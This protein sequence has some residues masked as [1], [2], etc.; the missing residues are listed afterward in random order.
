M[1]SERARIVVAFHLPF[2][3]PLWV[4]ERRG[5]FREEG[6]DVTIVTP[7]PG[8]TVD[9]IMSGEADL[10]LSGVMR[11]FILADRP[12]PRHLV[13]IAEVNSRDGF[14]I[15]SRERADGFR[16]SDL[17]GKRLALFGLAPTPWMCLQDVMRRNG[18]DPG[19]ITLLHG[20]G[21]AEGIAALRDGGA[22]YL[23]TGQPMA[24]ELLEDGVAH[25]AAAQ[26]PG[27]G[28]VPY[29]S[30]IVTPE[31]R[32]TRPDL[33]EKAVRALARALRWMAGQG[34]GAIADLIAPE[35]PDTRP[36][37]LHQVVGRYHAAGTWSDGP[38]QKREAFERLGAMLAAGGLIARAASYDALVDDTFAE[39]ATR[40][41]G[42]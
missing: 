26:A 34:G 18:V 6:L 7:P 16:W 11:S 35:F 41:V 21:V 25:L 3:T 9:M 31:V 30:F 10:A 29:S 38:R 24:E 37:I 22:D 8:K 33:C 20:L 13:A 28:H 15:L 36:A 19:T 14:F 2:Y 1:N 4:A 40:A 39:A 5:A 17:A 12:E 23:Q 32:R 27:V 42:G